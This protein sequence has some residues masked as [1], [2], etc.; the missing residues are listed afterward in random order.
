MR[1]I[2]WGA[3]AVAVYSLALVLMF[4]AA[5]PLFYRELRDVCAYRS[6]EAFYNPAPGA[7]WLEANGWTSVQYAWAYTGLYALFAGLFFAAGAVLFARKRGDAMGLLG[8]Y[9]LFTLGTT[10]I[11]VI[12][13]LKPLHP[14]LNGLVR[15][16]GAFGMPAFIVFVS[17]FPNGKLEP[18]WSRW[19]V[20]TVIA[21]R[22][23]GMLA[24]GTA[25]DIQNA[26]PVFAVWFVAWIGTMIFL[27]V[28]KYRRTMS[29]TER[30]QTKWAVFGCLAAIAGL[31]GWTAVYVINRPAWDANP[32]LMYVLELGIQ[33]S[34]CAIPVTLLIALL[35]YRLWNIDPLL[36]RTL[37][38]GI[39]TLCVVGL[40]AGS[41]G[42]LSL[43]FQTS[44][45][46]A[47]SFA[48]T[49]LVAVLFHPLRVRLQRMVSRWL[50]GGQGDPLATLGRLGER[51]AEPLAPEEALQAVA[52]SVREAVRAPYVGIALGGAEEP[53]AETGS[54]PRQPLRLPLIHRGER[55]G[56]LLLAMPAEGDAGGW[57]A[58]KDNG[59]LLELLSRQA[60]AVVQGVQATYEVQLLAADLQESR[61]RLVHA[62]EEERR[63]L[64]RN[65]HDD[66]A[67]RLASLLYT[68]AA[69]EQRIDREPAEA[70][71]M[72]AELRGHIR[73]TIADIR[74]LVYDLRPPALD[75][76]GLVG[77]IRERIADMAG[78]ARAGLAPSPPAA[79]APGWSF[80]LDA[81][82]ALPPLPAAVEV[83][84]YRI[85]TEALVNVAKH[86]RAAHCVVRLRAGGGRLELEVRDNGGD[87]RAAADRSA[88]APGGLGLASMRERAA[89]LGGVC[90]I[91]PAPGG[92]M[93]VQAWLPYEEVQGLSAEDQKREAGTA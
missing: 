35:R 41:V 76:L 74:T 86:T 62:R 59:K 61:E 17:L 63:R 79:G 89:E 58:A 55:V 34:M 77:A 43:L 51:L 36:S 29:P 93:V 28:Y 46:W 1:W 64:R 22:V 48:A 78:S 90:R 60:G 87:A 7:G 70:K 11:P 8:T 37:V 40:Y 53:V 72:L 42:Y 3:L 84:A 25:L 44:G 21:V 14:L 38:Y 85:A 5:L 18:G 26:M 2:R 19:L 49:G 92:G 31:A 23:P 75:E 12:D 91:E 54:R 65:L 39:L 68:S 6:C 50:Y 66:L 45:S 88:G 30:L 32:Y 27:L 4:A 67:P 9:M 71:A 81:P 16:V 82:E 13:A 47:I 52:R 20:L 24:P 57:G 15:W 80:E 69:A 10:F 83:A 56:T 33:L 73:R